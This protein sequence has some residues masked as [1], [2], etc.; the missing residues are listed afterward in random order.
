MLPPASTIPLYINLGKL[1]YNAKAYD[2]AAAAFEHA[3]QVDPNNVEAT[4]M[5]AET[6]NGQGRSAEAVTLIQ[7][8]IAARVAAGQKPEESWYKRAVK[9]AFDAKL[10][11]AA[12]IS[13]RMGG[14]LSEPEEL[15]RRDPHLPDD[16]AGSTM[17]R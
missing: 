16:A 14:G 11:N 5:L 17:P 13:P 3:L 2:K 15:A 1:Q 6:R 9:L 4:V 8:A 10:P 7:K 12:N